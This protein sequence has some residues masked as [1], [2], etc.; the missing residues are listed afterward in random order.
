[1]L[2]FHP[3]NANTYPARAG[4]HVVVQTLA[5]AVVALTSDLPITG[6]D[7]LTRC[8]RCGPSADVRATDRNTAIVADIDC[9]DIRTHLTCYGGHA[10]K[11]DDGSHMAATLAQVTAFGWPGNDR[12]A[13]RS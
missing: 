2:P 12:W 9:A 5:T 7:G 6:I 10:E 4:T 1:M 13:H 11:S 8:I 3:V